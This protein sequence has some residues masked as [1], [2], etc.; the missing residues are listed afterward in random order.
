MRARRKRE[1]AA[2]AAAARV[3]G[4]R[5]EL[6]V[7]RRPGRPQRRRQPVRRLRLAD[8]VGPAVADR[9]LRHQPMQQHQVSFIAIR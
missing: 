5:D 8:V 6:Q 3:P 9:N 2:A 1:M 4:P 7:D